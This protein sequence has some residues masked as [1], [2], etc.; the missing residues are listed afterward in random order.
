MFHIFRR[1]QSNKYGYGTSSSALGYVQPF[2][3]YDDFG[4]PPIPVSQFEHYVT[5][6]R[7][8]SDDALLAEYEVK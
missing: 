1:N 3:P 7:A 6:R 5:M 2:I 4:I 8:N